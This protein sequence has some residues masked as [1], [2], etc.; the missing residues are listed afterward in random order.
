MAVFW[1][2]F[3]LQPQHSRDNCGSNVDCSM[4]S[5]PIAI[6]LADKKDDATE[7]SDITPDREECWMQRRQH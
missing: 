7:A 3:V 6:P 4:P 2:R 5:L 1:S